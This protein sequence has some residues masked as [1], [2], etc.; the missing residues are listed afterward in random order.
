MAT[1][2]PTI[3]VS[4]REEF[5]SR[6]SR[7]L[8][9]SGKVPGVVYGAPDGATISFAADARELRR[10][11]V[12][13]GALIDL[14]VSGDTRPVILKDM[15][16]HPVRGDLVHVDFVQVR[17]DE[18]IQTTVPLHAEG[19]EDA[20]G[21]KEGGVLELPTH[22]LSIEALPTA[23]PDAITV[24]VSGLGMQETMHLSALTPPEGVTFLDDLE[25]TIVATIV[26]PS[27][28]PAEPELEEETE[29]VGE[30]GAAEAG[31][32]GATGDEAEQ[33]GEGASEA[34]SSDES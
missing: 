11:L 28:E 27:E 34:E 25:D 5:G 15:Q 2:R 7:R 1:S 16:L 13:S 18:K 20:P 26:I 4:V 21:V 30:E 19:G 24:D 6:V 14:K 32:E 10:V 22:T 33:A 3:D 23:I 12:G 31:A 8:R 29:L 9:K 17:L